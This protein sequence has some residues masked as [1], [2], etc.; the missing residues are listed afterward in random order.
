[1]D[2]F[3]FI[4]KYLSPLSGSGSFDLTDDIALLDTNII[5]V[6]LLILW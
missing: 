6:F 3:S 4:S 1:M 5:M 2:E